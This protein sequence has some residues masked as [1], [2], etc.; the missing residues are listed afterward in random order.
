M[1]NK[2]GMILIATGLVCLIASA[3]IVVA[4]RIEERNG[5][6]SAER[7]K[8]ILLQDVIPEI[9]P[10]KIDGYGSTATQMQTV[11]IDGQEYIGV[12]EL[13]TLELELPVLAKWSDELL[14]LS[15]C[16][17]HGSFLDDS[18]IIAGHNYRRHFSGIKGM[19]PGDPVIF[20]DVNGTVYHYLVEDLEK[21]AGRDLEGMET[22]EWD[23]T[24]FT[25]S[26]G[27][28]DRIAVR[29]LRETDGAESR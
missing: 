23:L 13:P 20:T 21:I 11:E 28:N 22:G 3:A 16:R 1:K 7:V 25:C 19:S 4:N 5:A 9:L 14:K 2:K 6:E 26:Y 27:G 24:L 10:G 17:Y 8:Q 18:M 15:P 12:L 29:C